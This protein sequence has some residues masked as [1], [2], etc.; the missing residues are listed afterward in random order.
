MQEA[1]IKSLSGADLFCGAGGF[2][3]GL[4]AAA[5]SLGYNVDLLAV[6]HW[7]IAIATHSANH[8]GV[9]HMCES[10]DAVEPR[11]VVPGGRLDILLASPECT[12][13][14][15][16]RGGKPMSDQSRATAWMV[17]RWAE[18]LYIP[19]ILI[20]NVREFRDWGP[21][22]ETGRPI[23]SKKGQLFRRFMSTLRALDYTVEDRILNAADYGDATTRKRLFIQARRGRKKITW[24]V[25]THIKPQ[26]DRLDLVDG[27]LPWK[28]ARDIIDWDKQGESIYTRKRPLS[29]NTVRRIMAGLE[30]YSGLPFLLPTNHGKHD[31]R[32]HAINSPFPTVTTCDAMALAQPFLV[33]LRNHGEGR[34]IDGPV[35]AI[36]A[37]GNH[38]G[39]AEPF[40]VKSYLGSDAASLD[41]PLPTIT[42]SVE[43]LR[44]LCGAEPFLVPNFGEREGQSPRCHSVESP[45]PAVTG[46]G[47][48]AVVQPMIVPQFASAKAKSVEQPLG[49]ITTTSRGVGLAE[50][51]LVAYHGDEKPSDAERRALSVDTPLGTLDTSNRFGLSQPF[52]VKYH[53]NEEHAHSVDDPLGTITS[54]DRYAL[55]S[56]ELV[57]QVDGEVVGWLD[58]RFRMLQP[59]ELA[60]AMS[61][62]PGYK[63]TGSREAQVKQIGNAVPVGLATALCREMLA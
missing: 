11:K 49:C 38:I 23:K 12:H 35:P 55:I 9:R 41:A 1:V 18:A 60:A 21:L 17:L 25:P 10:L 16:A 45:L 19:N 20:E 37:S 14:S 44:H 34:S 5:K 26:G 24:P 51:Y 29:P 22:D 48:G 27:A 43:H 6:N 8:P 4:I 63:F 40:L 7:E 28:P 15:N 54:R 46:H 31:S 36:L 42:A 53:G 33:V 52:L 3:S 57:N 56:P 2:S 61:F 59:N 32:T 13:H 58:I 30:K 50:P 39:L 62:P 47:A